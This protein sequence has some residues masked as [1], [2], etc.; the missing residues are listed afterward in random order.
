MQTKE[1]KTMVLGPRC[2]KS[3]F[4]KS[5]SGSDPNTFNI[6][7]NTIT[8]STTTLGTDVTPHDLYVNPDTKIRLNFWEVGSEFQGMGKDYCTNAKLAIIF[9]DDTD[10]HLEYED[11]IPQ[12]LPRVYVENY[13]ITYN[14][15]I[16]ERIC[17]EICLKELHL[18]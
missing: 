7:G 1:L 3:T 17:V 18:S 14:Q 12:E 4:I 15:N 13:H 5:L 8:I 2:G 16:L 11:W 6:N 10:N 9:K